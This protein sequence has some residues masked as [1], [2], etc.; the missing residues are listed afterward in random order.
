M[1]EKKQ[2]GTENKESNFVF[3]VSVIAII[4]LALFGVFQN[5]LY[6]Q[7]MS[8][9]FDWICQYFNWY[10]V[11]IITFYIIFMLFIAFSRYGK[12]K[13]GPDDSKPEFKTFSWLAMLF[14]AGMGSG[15]VFFGVAEPAYHFMCPPLG[16]TPQSVQAAELAMQLSFLHWGCHPW[17][18]YGITAMALGYFSMRKNK[19]MLIGNFVEPLFKEN[20]A[21]GDFTAKCID[22]LMVIVT[23]V[24]IASPLGVASSQLSAGIA[25]Y[26]NIPQSVWLAQIALA[27][28]AILFIYTAVSGLNKGIRYIA[29]LNVYLA[30]AICA[31]LLLFGPT[32]KLLQVFTS[33]LGQYV[34]TLPD[35]SLRLSPWDQAFDTWQRS[36]TILYWLWWL[37]W[38]PLCGVFF[39]RISYGRTMRELAAGILVAPPLGSFAWMTIFGGNAIDIIIKNPACNLANDSVNNMTMALWDLLEMFPLSAITIPLC[40]LLVVTFLVTSAN[41]GTFV[42]SMLSSNGIKEPSKKKLFTWGV[43]MTVIASATLFAGDFRG[44]LRLSGAIAFFYSL[45]TLFMAYALIKGMSAEFEKK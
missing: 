11:L 14:S 2:D 19:P 4:L 44:P 24:G 42:V 21:L 28:M 43:L 37:A 15:L 8:A 17:A 40:M 41:S 1:Q 6:G 29:D 10:L 45:V 25:K 3:N 35:W 32:L 9:A 26:F 12:I 34:A 7:V 18:I 13:L 36:W 5:K 22:S 27:V 31:F 23:A 38:G 30:I 39:A 16:V 20:S 33:S